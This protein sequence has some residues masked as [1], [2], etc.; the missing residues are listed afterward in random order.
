MSRSVRPMAR[1]V[2]SAYTL[3]TANGRGIVP[4]LR[5]LRERRS[6]LRPCDFEDVTLKTYIGRVAGL[7]DFSLDDEL[8]RFDCRNNRLAW[9]GL[10]Q[11]GFMVAVAEAK[12]RYGAHRIAVHMDHAMPAMAGAA[13]IFGAG[14]IGGVA[15]RP[16]QGRIGIHPVVDGLAVHGKAAHGI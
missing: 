7:E 6:G 5:A 1:L 4:V 13:A 11:D 2:L 8:E 15:Q 14:E 3:V 16:E 9:L 12:Q 10:Q